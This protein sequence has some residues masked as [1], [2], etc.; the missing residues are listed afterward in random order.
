VTV[1]S[2]FDQYADEYDA[3]VQ[4]A[5]GASGETVAFFADLKARLAR[6]EAPSAR[7]VLDFGCGVGNMS[8]ALAARFPGAKIAGCDPSAES[9][10]TARERSNAAVE[11]VTTT[12]H[13][14]P[15]ESG[16][17][18]LVVAACVFHHIDG[19]EQA[20]WASEMARVLRPGGQVAF[21][22][23]NP[24]NP[25]TQRVV[26]NVPFDAEAVLLRRSAADGLLTRAGFRVRRSRYYFFFP[27][28]LAALRPLEPLMGWIPFGGQ[29]Y[30]IGDKP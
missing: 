26:R 30:V 24:L 4:A 3:T 22:E 1:R 6:H 25:L 12:G 9:I 5:I 18:D 7:R 8:R 15:F 19:R 21:F 23:H 16:T 11:F 20:H 29:Y 2:E 28:L 13:Q 10:A 14:L 27:R 17:F